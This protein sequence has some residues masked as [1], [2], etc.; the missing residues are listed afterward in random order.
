MQ[1][2]TSTYCPQF[3]VRLSPEAHVF[4]KVEF[5]HHTILG[6]CRDVSLA[7]LK[8]SEESDMICYLQWI[9]ILSL[10]LSF[11]FNAA[12]IKNKCKNSL[13]WKISNKMAS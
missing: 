10:R 9:V 1:A 12:I 11:L 6:T 13:L 5:S 8:F 7:E 2:L 4:P 3:Y